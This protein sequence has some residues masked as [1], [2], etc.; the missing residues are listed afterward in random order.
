MQL[1]TED[2]IQ[3]LVPNSSN[4]QRLVINNRHRH[5]HRQKD[6]LN[7]HYIPL[8]RPAST[9]NKTFLFQNKFFKHASILYKVRETIKLFRNKTY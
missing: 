8:H 7:I 2:F 1:C 5:V 3:R 9:A 4:S 6:R